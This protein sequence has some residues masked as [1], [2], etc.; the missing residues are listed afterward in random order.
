MEDF[1]PFEIA[2]QLKEKGFNKPC[3]G[4]YY[5]T[6]TCAFDH[7]Q[8][9]VFNHSEFRGATYDDLLLPLHGDNINAPTISQVLK[10]LREEKNIYV[11]IAYI[12]KCFNETGVLND[13]YYPTFQK[14]GL[15]E[16]MFFGNAENYDTYNYAAL[17]GI[18]YIIDNLI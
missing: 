6:P 11:G 12:P 1:V 7:K 3:F 18:E 14:I 8:N 17:A 9:I 2:K 4:W 5:A 15:F 13:F 10:W 16:P